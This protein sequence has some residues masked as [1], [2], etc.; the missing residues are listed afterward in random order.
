MRVVSFMILVC[1]ATLIAGCGD[2]YGGR[3][4]VSGEIKLKGEPLKEGTIYF[5]PA[6]GQGSQANVFIVDGK[7]NVERKEGLLPGKYV[8]RISAGDKKTNVNEETEA[9]GP[10]GAANMTFF[11]MIPPEWNVA[12]TKEVTVSAKGE[13]VFNFDIPK[14]AVPKKGR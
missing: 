8:I 5:A 13:N 9:G 12:S 6:E 4:A 10:G 3:M 1:S 14:A 2:S 11:D 7:Y